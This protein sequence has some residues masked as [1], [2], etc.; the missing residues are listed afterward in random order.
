MKKSNIRGFMIIIILTGLFVLLI[1]DTEGVL[2]S[3]QKAVEL[4][5][6]VIVPTLLPFFI[7]SRLI[8]NTGAISAIGRIFGPVIR[9]LFNLPGSAAFPIIAGWFSGYPA[10][11]KYTSDLYKKGMITK[12]QAE[13]LLCFCNNSGPLFIV[14]AVGT[15]YFN[16]P[17]LGLI[18]LLCHIMASF[19]V[20]IIQRFIF[21]DN[22]EENVNVPSEMPVKIEFSSHMLTDAIIDSTAVLLRICGT[23]V[24]FAV[25]VQTLETAGF[26]TLLSSLIAFVTGLNISDYIKIITAG[27][28]E[29][30][31]GL[32]LLSRSMAIPVHLKILLT[33]FLCGFGG[34]SVF[35][36]VTFF[37]PPEIKLKKYLFGKLI[38]GFAASLFTGLF[39]IN[40]TVPVMS[41]TD[42]IYDTGTSKTI[43]PVYILILSIMIMY[44]LIAHRHGKKQRRLQ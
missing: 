16:S 21:K 11:A 15:G 29:I 32:Y 26:F 23:I 20:G 31:Y 19:T 3:G 4:C 42:N 18:L 13:R 10:G 2:S 35:T 8:L 39:L 1:S 36:Q 38:H 28:F 43:M 34:F 7:I 37:C 33:S 17:E 41:H 27:S 6:K 14:G 24:F 22:S 5:L 40:R 25:L 9:P 44:F 12:K 30:T